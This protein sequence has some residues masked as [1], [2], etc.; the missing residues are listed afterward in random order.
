[1][2][3]FVYGALQRRL[4]RARMISGGGVSDFGVELYFDVI[5]GFPPSTRMLPAVWACSPLEMGQRPTIRGPLLGFRGKFSPC[6]FWCF[7]SLNS[8]LAP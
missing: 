6:S 3:F 4:A 8:F 7:G 5:T 1:V 2:F